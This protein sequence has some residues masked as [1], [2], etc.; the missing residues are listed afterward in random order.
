MF[1]ASDHV[2]NETMKDI[3]RKESKSPI[4]IENL[5]DVIYASLISIRF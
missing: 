3:F 4:H 2:A 5:Y 1:T